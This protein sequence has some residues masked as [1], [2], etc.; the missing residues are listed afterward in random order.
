MAFWVNFWMWL[1]L[2]GLLLFLGLAVVVSIGG[3]IDIRAL[4]KRVREQQDEER[5]DG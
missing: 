2:F 3:L 5:A 1:L 4:F